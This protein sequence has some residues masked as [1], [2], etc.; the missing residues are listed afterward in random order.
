MMGAGI[1]YGGP[2]CMDCGEVVTWVGV[3]GAC[4]MRAVGDVASDMHAVIIVEFWAGFMAGGLPYGWQMR[5]ENVDEYEH[6]L[7]VVGP[8]SRIKCDF[9]VTDSWS[10]YA[11]EEM[12]RE[13]AWAA[14]YAARPRMDEQ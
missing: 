4:H 7:S 9:R 2:N 3:C 12:L 11:A 6:D 14:E 10:H 5:A 1:T 13:K 8:G